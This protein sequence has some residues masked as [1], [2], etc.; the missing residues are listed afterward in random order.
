MEPSSFFK[1]GE[2]CVYD[3]KYVKITQLI[4]VNVDINDMPD[5]KNTED[6]SS[7]SIL[8]TNR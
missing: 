6:T 2:Y 4:S 1:F 8:T 7:V 5:L 3:L